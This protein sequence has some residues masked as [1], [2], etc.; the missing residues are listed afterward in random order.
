M[1]EILEFQSELFFSLAHLR[2]DPLKCTQTIVQEGM[3]LDAFFLLMTPSKCQSSLHK[4][5]NGNFAHEMI[6]KA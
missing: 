1:W 6:E 5:N 3:H 4:M 2:E